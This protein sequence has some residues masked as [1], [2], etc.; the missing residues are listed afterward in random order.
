MKRNGLQLKHVE[1]F[2]AVIAG[3]SASEGARLLGMSQP[4]VSKI[5]AQAEELSGLKLFDRRLGRLIPTPLAFR[6]Y[7]ETDVLFSTIDNIDQIVERVIRSEVQPIA[8]GA[9]PL[10]AVTLLPRVL[11]SWQQESGR[12]LF[13]R[14]YDTPNLLNLL[15]A[16]RLD[17]GIAVTTPPGHGLDSMRLV[18]SPLYCAVPRD[19][20]LAGRSVIHARDLDGVN[21][22]SLSRGESAQAEIDRMFLTEKSRPV[23]KMQLPLMSAAVKMVEQGV[24]LTFVDA[25]AMSAADRLRLVFRRFEPVMY[26]EY[27]V[28]WARAK[29]A[30]FDRVG[31]IEKLNASAEETL[32]EADRLVQELD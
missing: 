4:A 9:L 8:L 21:Y 12:A 1:A 22:V 31:L 17:L 27:L 29:E 11:P 18:R 28:I 24:G 20:P 3:G 14:T 32:K 30:D 5:I 2:R 25:F 15:S 16:Q 23:E 7:N 6:L 10:I 19:H 26:F 13:V